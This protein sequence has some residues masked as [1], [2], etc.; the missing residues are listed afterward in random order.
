MH[1]IPRSDRQGGLRSCSI[2]KLVD[3]PADDTLVHAPGI[4]GRSLK[5]ER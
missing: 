4:E 2:D 3:N 1:G 5:P